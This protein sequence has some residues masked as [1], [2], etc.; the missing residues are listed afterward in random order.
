M[1]A[2][3]EPWKHPL[4]GVEQTKWTPAWTHEAQRLIEDIQ[5]SL[6]NLRAFTEAFCVSIGLGE[7]TSGLSE[8]SE[9]ERLGTLLMRPEAAD[10]ELAAFFLNDEASDRLPRALNDLKEI[11][12][13]ARAAK[14]DLDGDYAPEA[15]RLDLARLQRDWAEA[16]A[17]NFLFREG[18][19][20]KVRLLLSPYCKGEPPQDIGRDLVG[21]QRLAEIVAETERVKPAFAGL[22]RLWRGADTDIPRT[23]PDDR[24]GERHA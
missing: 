21:L 2:V 24:M 4:R 14:I 10:G 15:I 19:K 17:A 5:T 23:R 16:C 3:G 1:L 12:N 18:K 6:F 9:L 7:R 11:V 8:L 13:R 22:E 20:S